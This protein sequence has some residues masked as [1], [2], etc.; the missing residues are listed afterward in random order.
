MHDPMVVAFEVR[1]PWPKPV[2]WGTEGARFSLARRR[3]PDSRPWWNP[4]AWYFRPVVAGR[5]LYFPAMLVIWH[6]EPGGADSGQVCKHF[7]RVQDHAGHWHT[8][9]DRRWRLHVHHW[10]LQV[11]PLQ[12]LRRWL[13]T[14]CAW[15]WG[16]STRRDPINVSGGGPRPP[17]RWWRGETGLYHLDCYGVSRAHSSCLCPTGWAVLEHVD[18]G[19]C[20]RCGKRRPYGV[21]ESALARARVLAGIPRGARNRETYA[22]VTAMVAAER[23]NKRPADRPTEGARS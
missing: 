14:R 20:A 2:R 10:R 3:R 23:A 19:L 21:T 1:R 11:P 17:R 15:C 16:R 13:L 4:R 6:V 8:L 5:R 12:R 7:R 18:H 22:R 9:Y